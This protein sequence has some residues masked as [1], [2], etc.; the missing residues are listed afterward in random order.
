MNYVVTK[1]HSISDSL[2]KLGSIYTSVTLIAGTAVAL[3]SYRLLA[4]QLVDLLYYFRPKFEKESDRDRKKL[5]GKNIKTITS[6]KKKLDVDFDNSIE[7]LLESNTK[8]RRTSKSII[9]LYS[10]ASLKRTLLDDEVDDDDPET[11][12]IKQKINKFVNNKKASLKMSAFDFFVHDL[13][14]KC[15]C[16]KNSLR[17]STYNRKILN[18]RSGLEHLNKELDIGVVLKKLRMFKYFMKTMLSKN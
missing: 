12:E 4:S 5:D 14:C 13:C 15:F 3:V 10:K 2:S 8:K 17:N 16:S 9:G 11:K 7:D 6:V 18:Y 1:V